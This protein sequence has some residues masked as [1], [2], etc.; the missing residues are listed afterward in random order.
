MHFLK[1]TDDTVQETVQFN[2]AL[3]AQLMDMGFPI[4]ACKRAL[5]STKNENLENATNWL[6]EHID[7][8]SIMEPFTLTKTST[9][10][11][12]GGNYK[13]RIG[14]KNYSSDKS[15][16]KKSKLW[17]ILKIRISILDVSLLLH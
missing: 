1:P 14:Q 7:D 17:M 5:H 4:D 3:L 9:N 8:P 13:Y 10:R 2:E 16:K 11:A 15:W 6:M 12:A